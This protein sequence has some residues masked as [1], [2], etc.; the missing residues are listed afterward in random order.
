[1]ILTGKWLKQYIVIISFY[2][3]DY[4]ST[5]YY[6]KNPLQEWNK[7]AKHLMIYFDS[8]FIGM[9]VFFLSLTIL[10]YILIIPISIITES[11]RNKSNPFWFNTLTFTNLVLFSLVCAFDFGFGATSWF[12]NVDIFYRITTG[13]LLYLLIDYYWISA[14]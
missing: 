10:W 12:W 3:V 13:G 1:M 11:Y 4:V 5:I 9:T 8:L 14:E 7:I 6:I 2:F